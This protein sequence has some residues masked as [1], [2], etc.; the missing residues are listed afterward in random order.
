MACALHAITSKA[1]KGCAIVSR[2]HS[3]FAFAVNKNMFSDYSFNLCRLHF[4][5]CCVCS[6]LAIAIQL[7]FIF[8]LLC[9]VLY[10]CW[11]YRFQEIQCFNCKYFLFLPLQLKRSW[12]R[13]YVFCSSVRLCG[14]SLDN[15]M[16]SVLQS[17]DAHILS[18]QIQNMFPSEEEKNS[19]NINIEIQ[20]FSLFCCFKVT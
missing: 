9:L 5:V 20:N 16:D 10:S 3:L 1:K 4:V 17:E 11:I 13:M 15:L 6:M 2:V 12:L 8:F 18:F 14:Q 7:I 19:K